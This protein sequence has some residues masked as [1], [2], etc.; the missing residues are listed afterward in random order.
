MIN[1][2]ARFAYFNKN[3]GIP[4]SW[5]ALPKSAKLR[6]HAASIPGACRKSRPSRHNVRGRKMFSKSNS[7][8]FPAYEWPS[9][10]Y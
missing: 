10:L 3:W 6:K 1:G 9:K 7:K 2:N 8:P 4:K 5:R